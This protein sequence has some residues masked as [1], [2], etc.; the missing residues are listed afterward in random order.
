M[1]NNIENQ[2]K[3]LNEMLDRFYESTKADVKNYEYDCQLS[4]LES[5]IFIMS[6]ETMLIE[7]EY[8]SSLRY[9]QNKFNVGTHKMATD[10]YNRYLSYGVQASIYKYLDVMERILKNIDGNF[11]HIDD[12]KSYDLDEIYNQIYDWMWD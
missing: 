5:R 1:Q 3:E 8:Y 10:L 12:Y 11:K 9:Y 4:N 6:I 2:K 7:N